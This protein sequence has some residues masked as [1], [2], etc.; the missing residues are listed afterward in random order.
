MNSAAA[1]RLNAALGVATDPPRVVATA[2]CD[3]L[4]RARNESVIGWP[5]KF[6]ARVNAVF[7]QLVDRSLARSLPVVKSHATAEQPCE[8]PPLAERSPIKLES[9]EVSS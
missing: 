4:E 2:V 9:T 5:E 3:A 7:P 6:Y 1:D 8:A